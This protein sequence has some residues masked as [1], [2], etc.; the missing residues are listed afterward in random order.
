MEETVMKLRLMATLIVFA[1]AG[2][3][4]GGMSMA[5][6]TGS[7]TA[8]GNVNA[9]TAS[10]DLY[11]CEPENS[12][13]PNCGSDDSGA[14]E[15]IF[16]DLENLLPGDEWSAWMRLRNTGANAWYI[17]AAN[18][19]VTEVSDPGADCDLLPTADTYLYG[20]TVVET[21][22]HDYCNDNTPT[23]TP[24]WPSGELQAFPRWPSLPLYGACGSQAGSYY[25]QVRP[26]DYEDMV[27]RVRLPFNAPAGCE[28]NVWD[29][30]VE[31]Q[32]QAN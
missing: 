20:K 25:V 13:G 23:G 6:W 26:N 15:T 2:G 24:S 22:A 31:W 21:G 9:T 11:I 4:A 30:S 7:Q 29:I 5:L 14:D 16:E 8:S 28:D 32:V 1:A 27:V 10:A 17:L 19:V 18:P 3:L 12:I